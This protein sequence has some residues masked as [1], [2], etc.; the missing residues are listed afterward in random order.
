MVSIG[1]K[2]DRPPFK[3]GYQT[4]DMS[5]L[6]PDQELAVRIGYLAQKSVLH[7]PF[8]DQGKLKTQFVRF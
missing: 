5:D 7:L 3:T 6:D 2:A 1:P 8:T 4:V